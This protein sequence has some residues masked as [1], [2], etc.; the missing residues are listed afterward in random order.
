[1]N[2]LCDTACGNEEKKKRMPPFSC[3]LQANSILEIL[4]RIIKQFA[5]FNA[6]HEENK[7]FYV[8]N[9]HFSAMEIENMNES[10]F[11]D[12]SNIRVEFGD[13]IL[14]LSHRL[15]KKLRTSENGPQ[16]TDYA[17]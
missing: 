12:Y 14:K 7:R 2:W 11:M 13:L 6:L 4:N 3:T 9:T 8:C 15:E 10:L 5:R 17:Q 16:T 1:M